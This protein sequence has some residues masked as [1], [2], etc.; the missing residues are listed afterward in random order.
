MMKKYLI[1]LALLYGG[2]YYYTRY[3]SVGD[4]IE[5]AKAHKKEDW[6]PAVEYYAGIVYYQRSDYPKAQAAFTQLLADY[7]TG[8]Y[9]AKALLKVTDAAENNRDWETA[10][11][12]LVR[13]LDEFPGDKETDFARKKLELMKYQH[14]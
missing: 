3:V 2:Y 9:T 13:F 12:S 6:A 4:P 7:P 1:G 8:Q 14:P 5:F 11:S 10:K